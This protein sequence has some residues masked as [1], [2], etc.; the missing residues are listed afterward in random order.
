LD[1]DFVDLRL[2]STFQDQDKTVQHITALDLTFSIWRI[3]LFLYSL[4][5]LCIAFN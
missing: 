3:C 1:R 5:L 4:Q 2:V